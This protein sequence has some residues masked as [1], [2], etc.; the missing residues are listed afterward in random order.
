MSETLAPLAYAQFLKDRMEFR[1]SG[2]RSGNDFN[3][4]DSP[5]HK[6]FK[7][8][9]YFGGADNNNGLESNGLLHPTWAISNLNDNFYAFNSAWS[10]LKMNDE[11]DRADKLEKFIMLLSNINSYSPWYFKSIGGIDSALERSGPG[12]EKLDIGDN[13][14]LTI[15]CSPDAFDNR[16]TTL[17]ELYRDITW[18]WS[19]KR[20]ILPVNLRKFD[21][22]IYIF[23]SPVHFWHDMEDTKLDGPDSMYKPSYKMLEFHD[24]EFSYNSLKSGWGEINNETGFNPTYTIEISYGDCYEVSYN[25]HLM[26]TIGDV[27]ATDTYQAVIKDNV[28]LNNN[29]YISEKQPD[30]V[31]QLMSVYNRTRDAGFLENAVNQLIGTGVKHVKEKLTSAVLGNLYT[32]SLTKIGTQI[33]EAAK[34]NLIKTGQSIK[35]YIKN[36][37]ERAAAKVKQKPSGNLGNGYDNYNGQNPNGNLGTGY[38][39]YNKISADGEIFDSTPR[40]FKGYGRS[41]GNLGKRMAPS[42]IVN[43]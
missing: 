5:G 12:A 35:Q 28:N 29:S 8:L 14:K 42:S 9:F 19:Q 6:F 11:N 20:Q 22:A 4:F 31:I 1:K 13:K 23:E 15:A 43:N 24:C 17:L 30:S 26:R 21:M 37:Q 27:I 34:G 10:F 32:Y 18:S 2:K 41:F 39:T 40:S 25:E 16:L 36:E 38:E 33:G 3:V 7:I